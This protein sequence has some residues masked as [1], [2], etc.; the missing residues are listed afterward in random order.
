MTK[1][2]PFEIIDGGLSAEPKPKKARP[3][4]AN[5]KKTFWECKRCMVDMGFTTRSVLKA[6]S[7]PMQDGQLRISEGYETWVCVHCLARGKVTYTDR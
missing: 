1:P 6:K 2:P 7:A 3:S 5:A 4:R